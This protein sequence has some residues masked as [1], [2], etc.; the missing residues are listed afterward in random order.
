MGCLQRKP[1]GMGEAGLQT[2]TTGAGAG[3]GTAASLK[4]ILEGRGSRACVGV[5]G[6][7][8]PCSWGTWVCSVSDIAPHPEQGG[9]CC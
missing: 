3:L 6:K 1:P 7:T 8:A 5:S 9:M 4:G 2:R